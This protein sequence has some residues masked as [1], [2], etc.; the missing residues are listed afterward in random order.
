MLLRQ[1]FDPYLAQYAYLIGCQRTGEAL[2]ID[3]E[4]DI[5]QYQKLASENG[6]R[7]T[8]VAETHIHA[9]FVSGGREFAEDPD[10]HLYLSDEGGPGWTYVWPRSRPNTHRLK[11]GD[12]FMV[13]NIKVE[14]IHTPGHT[15]EH[16]SFLITDLGGGADQPIALA[17][18]DF[19]FVGDVGRPDLLESAAGVKNVM[20]PSARAL[21]HSL[22]ERLARFTDFLQI[23]PAHGAGSAC[24]KSL[25]AV[26]TTTLGYERRFNAPLKLAIRDEEAFVKDILQGQP[27]PPLYFATMKRVNR[28]GI[29]VTR[30]I[31]T[32]Q[33]L[34]AEEARRLITTPSVQILDT[35]ADRDAYDQ[36]HAPRSITCPLRTPF[37]PNAA[38]SFLSDTDKILLVVEET[39]DADLAT[40]QLYRIGF[41]HI[42]GWITAAEATAAGLLSEK[43]DSV[44]FSKFND[45]HALT[46][47]AIIDVRTSAEYQSGHLDG[48]ISL[49]YTRMKEHLSSIP[50]GKKLFVH[51]ASGKRASLAT[52]FLRSHGF[53]VIHVDGAYTPL[54]SSCSLRR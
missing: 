41:D 42:V 11:D 20:E 54:T 1:V 50:K 17:T 24:G 48:A 23:L 16:M 7:I 19:L 18:G 47:G 9:D 51:C 34:P 29:S 21:R 49:P 14:A 46:E 33:H 31:H 43:T 6:L 32:S 22:R 30:G 38:G 12:S 44:P 52:S 28:D 53:D 27:D 3:P 36:G 25:G 10:L 5:D 8:A 35:R 40:R 39:E 2:V 26:P 4:R 15:P 45:S 37:F 13:G